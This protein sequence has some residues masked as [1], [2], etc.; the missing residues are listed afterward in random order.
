LQLYSLGTP[1]G[2][3]VTIMLEELNQALGVE[4]DAWKISFKES[5]Q[6]GS[7][8]VKINPNSKIPAMLDYSF[9]EEKPVRVFESAS[10]LKYLAEKYDSFL[11]PTDLPGKTEC[12]NW[13]IFQVGGGP[14]MGGAGF[15]FW[16]RSAPYKFK[17]AIDRATIEVKRQLDVLDKELATKKYLCGDQYSIA[18]IALWPWI[19]S[20]K[21]A[22]TFLSFS[23]DYP[24][25]VAW[26][27]T[28]K[29]RPAV[30]RGIR[31]T[32]FGDDAVPERHSKDDFIS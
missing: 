32:G 15:G 23:K 21:N 6:F 24:H 5:D 29:E 16:Y 19:R 20:L 4:Y 14:Y 31:V 17:F 2:C 11:V 25:L 28:I 1:N 22:D 27:D 3:K 9:D 18:D 10:I 26:F 12:F 7:D 8:F 30:K 13:L